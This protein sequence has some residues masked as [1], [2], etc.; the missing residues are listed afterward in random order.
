MTKPYA[1]KI[2]ININANNNM[3]IGTSMKGIGENPVAIIKGIVAPI[4]I[5]ALLFPLS[6]KSSTDEILEKKSKWLCK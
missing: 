4:I 3:N 1:L 6:I 5:F 2:F